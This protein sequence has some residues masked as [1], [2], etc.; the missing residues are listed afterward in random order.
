MNKNSDL[1]HNI[2]KLGFYNNI[3]V[4]FDEVDDI[5]DPN[6]NVPIATVMVRKHTYLYRA[7]LKMLG[8]LIEEAELKEQEYGFVTS[9][10]IEAIEEATN[11]SWEEV[12]KKVGIE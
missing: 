7:S 2:E 12:K 10:I 8:A 9:P 4:D 3:R 5:Y 1:L 11:R 6:A